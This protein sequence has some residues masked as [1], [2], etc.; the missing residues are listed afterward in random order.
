MKKS[1]DEFRN[2]PLLLKGV[3]WKVNTTGVWNS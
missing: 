2:S 3:H 1:H